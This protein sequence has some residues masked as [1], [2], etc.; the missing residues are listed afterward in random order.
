MLA[1]RRRASSRRY[2]HTLTESTK[3]F[4]VAGVLCYSQK[5]RNTNA[6]KLFPLCD[7]AQHIRMYVETDVGDVVDMLAGHEVGYLTHLPLRE[8]LAQAGH[9]SGIHLFVAGQQ[10]YIV[11]RSA[12]GPGKQRVGSV[13]VERVEFGGVGRGL[14]R[15]VP[16]N[17][18][19]E[20]AHVY[21]SHLYTKQLH[22]I[23]GQL[24]FF[25]QLGYLAV[26]HAEC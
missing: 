26:E 20:E 2:Y 5:F 14:Y 8:V 21:P 7:I 3:I 6:K 11:Q 17:V 9:G 19:T 10:G 1:A 4:W 13:A 24:Q 12:L 25:V 18:Y 23:M 16:A 22:K 15:H